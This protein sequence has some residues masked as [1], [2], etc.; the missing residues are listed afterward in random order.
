[1]STRRCLLCIYRILLWLYPATFRKRFAAEM[2]EFA[3]AAEP[4]EWPL[5]FGD[6]SVAIVRSWL[7]GSPSTVAAVEPDAY[8]SLGGSSIRGWG[9]LQG[10]VLSIAIIGGLWYANYR[11]PYYRLCTGNASVS[12]RR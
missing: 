6:T 7:A 4:K 12:A 10:L 11:V 5:I 8:L 3:E 9:L 1:M 2:L